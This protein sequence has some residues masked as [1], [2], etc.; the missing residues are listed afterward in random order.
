MARRIF[1]TLCLA[2]IAMLGTAFWATAARA[3]TASVQTAWRLLDYIAVDYAG[4]VADGRVIST[5]EYAEM[6]EFSAEVQTRMREL[7]DATA[8]GLVQQAD[9]LAA[10]IARKAPPA[11]VA[12]QARALGRALLAAHPVP[13]APE[14]LPDPA[15]GR[16]LYAAQCAS[17]HGLDGGGNGP[18]AANLDPP[19]ID[20]TDATRARQRSV[21][22]LQQVVEQ[23]IDGTA[24]PSFAHLSAEDRWALAFYIG[25]FAYPEALAPAGERLWHDR[26]E[27][28]RQITNLDA[29]TG[30]TPAALAE[31]LGED[32]ARALTAYLRATP[33]VVLA[34]HGHP[35]ALTRERLA[36]SLTAYK[37]GDRR[38]AARLA[39]S[40]Y[41]DGFEP[42]EPL[43][44]T[45]DAA[46]M[47][48]I[49]R[50]MGELRAA[51]A[52]AAPAS[53]VAARVEALD[54]LFG[55]AE[56]AL[57]PERASTASSFIGALTILLR[58][59]LEALL[60]V[61]AMVAFLRKAERPEV[62]PYV[63]GGWIAALAAGGLTWAAATKLIAVSG[64][65]RELTEGVG[66]L[67]AAV[68]LLSVGIWMHGKAQADAW[69]R[70]IR[71]KLTH[72][73]S[74]RS[75]WF[76]FGLAFVVV[77]REAFETILFFTALWSDG[78]NGAVAAGAAAATATLA[79]IAWAMLRYSRRLP[80]A[81]FFRYSSALIA[82]LAVVLAGKGV[83][84]LQEAGVL[85]VDP[86]AGVPRLD[87]FGL[88]PTVEVV[89]AQL[90]TVAALTVGF[91]YNRRSA[92][93]RG[94]PHLGA[95]E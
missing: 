39:L 25:R 57:A 83:A 91:W 22:A 88:Y 40:A 63:H 70:Y 27:L 19:P 26:P 68:V 51:I 3:D 47:P 11:E 44:A 85:G 56:A 61:V 18:A 36:E 95:A 50:A 78:N 77:Y 32:D 4:A 24:M 49:E 33:E 48:R 12:E 90:I 52:R 93:R 89:A 30:L 87:A 54:A 2:L 41:L 1:Q 5:A 42:V 74:R 94:P 16:A 59:G 34:S 10:T 66:G 46:L 76:L 65:S 21:F 23:G 31:R 29:L 55:E 92:N 20:F 8:K 81:Q 15:R 64:A 37:S 6:T 35:L 28:R 58:E 62:L 38:E 80:I 45:R 67:F 84:A 53:D 9:A 60:V 86:L 14:R 82:V 79:G 13:L 75:A 7:P 17:C 43:L 69:Q 71:A 72:A 73:L